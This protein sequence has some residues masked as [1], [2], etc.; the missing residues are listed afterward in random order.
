MRSTGR[1]AIEMRCYASEGTAAAVAVAGTRPM[2]TDT[3]YT[4]IDLV[5]A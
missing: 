5:L 2:Q 3:G 1:I 4:S